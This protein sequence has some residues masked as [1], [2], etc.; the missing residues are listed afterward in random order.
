MT[1]ADPR[2]PTVRLS[3]TNAEQDIHTDGA[4]VIG[5]L[6]LHAAKSGG[7][8]RIVS[9]VSVFD[10]MHQ[11]RPD[12][13]RLLFEP[14]HFHL[15]GEHAPGAQP[16]FSLPIVRRVGGQL[17]TFFIGWYI[18]DAT[19]L[20]AVP[21]LTQARQ[22][23]LSLYEAIAN[24][25]ALYLDM[26]FRRRDI[27]WLKNSVILHKR[28]SYEDH[29]EPVRKRHLWRLWL[30]SPDFEDGIVALR[31]GHAAAAQASAAPRDADHA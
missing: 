24:D 6:C 19:G 5:L 2:D 16:Y 9:S 13:A 23:A 8:S 15:K 17:S 18:R 4:D 28:M 1:G 22:D 21:P 29:D 3:T 30:A 26:D 27:Q 12:L 11:A 31:R 20:P 7:Q 10:T 25:P 14:W